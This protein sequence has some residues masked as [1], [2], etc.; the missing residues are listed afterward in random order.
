MFNLKTK[1]ILLSFIV[2]LLVL[3]W[4]YTVGSK[5]SDVADFKHQLYNQTFSQAFAHFLLWAIPASEIT[6]ATLLLFG[7]TR[8]IGLILSFLLMLVFTGYVALVLLHYYNRVPCSCG[9]VLK[10]L[11]WQ[12]HLGFNLFFLFLS[13]IGIIFTFKR[14]VIGKA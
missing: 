10:Q 14:E 13:V 3:L 7:K 1:Q 6:A 5:L 2:F 9:G 4:V 12:A 8:L 11:G